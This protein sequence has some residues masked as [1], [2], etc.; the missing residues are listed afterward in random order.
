MTPMLFVSKQNS[1]ILITAEIYPFWWFGKGPRKYSTFKM[2][3]N[4]SPVFNDNLEKEILSILILRRIL[5]F[6]LLMLVTNLF[7]IVSTMLIVN[8]FLIV[9]SM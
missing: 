8:R 4:T 5:L 6:K 9:N 3:T 2:S 1:G 7:L